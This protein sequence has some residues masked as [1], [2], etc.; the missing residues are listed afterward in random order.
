MIFVVEDG[1][2][3]SDATS[4][5][6]LEYA[7]IYADSFFSDTE[8]TLWSNANDETL[9]R[10]LNRASVYLDRTYVFHGERS[11]A[12]QALEFPRASLYDTLGN[13]ITGISTVIQQATCIAAS[14]MLSGVELSPDMDRRTIREKIDT[15]DI[16][17]ASDSSSYKRFTELDNL[18]KSSGFIKNNRNSNVNIRLTQG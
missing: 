1:T 3:K 17:Y 10:L 4:Y 6:A 8:Y 5:V 18:L 7:E 12:T 14:K 16:T 2:G 13:E 9:K 11:L 15:I